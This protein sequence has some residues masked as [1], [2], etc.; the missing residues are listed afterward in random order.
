[1]IDFFFKVSYFNYKKEKEKKAKHSGRRWPG[2][3][4]RRRGQVQAL[5]RGL[6]RGYRLRSLLQLLRVRVLRVRR[7]V[8]H[9]MPAMR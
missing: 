1:L 9:R 7:R 4:Q 6:N 5:Q 2:A 8:V 3:R